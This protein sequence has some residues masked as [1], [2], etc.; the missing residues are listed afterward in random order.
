MQLNSILFPAPK[1]SYSAEQLNG[2]L[3]WVPKLRKTQFPLTR[4]STLQS[5]TRGYFSQPSTSHHVLQDSKKTNIPHVR[6]KKTMPKAGATISESSHNH[7]AN[8]KG[9]MTK[10][11]QI[12]KLTIESCRSEPR[13]YNGAFI[14]PSFTRQSDSVSPEI[15]VLE[16]S[17]IMEEGPIELKKL[18]NQN[19]KLLATNEDE[20]NLDDC[21]NYSEKYSENVSITLD[22]IQVKRADNETFSKNKRFIKKDASQSSKASKSTAH[23][24]ISIS[25]NEITDA[26]PIAHEKKAP[27]KVLQSANFNGMNSPKSKQAVHKK[28]PSS[29]KVITLNQ[30]AKN[31]ISREE[32]K[33]NLEDEMY[34]EYPST[35]K[36]LAS[37]RNLP[38][39]QTRT[40]ANPS[41]CFPLTKSFDFDA[42][43]SV[44]SPKN[45][46]LTASLA[47]PTGMSSPSHVSSPTNRFSSNHATSA[48][49]TETIEYY[50][51]CMVLKS[52][53]PTSKMLIYF[54]GNGEDIYLAYDL[55]SHIR[56]NLSVI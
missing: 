20:V 5:D 23:Q 36:A 6:S 28:K 56:N 44:R 12:D 4:F 18:V 13:I 43:A 45:T 50:I 35:A 29:T 21:D 24:D 47:I 54:H 49:P 10:I 42:F 19:K 52:T 25:Q 26:P 41:I 53:L 17:E 38:K 48:K 22:E 37:P 32:S 14:N 46:H 27:L 8:T 51:P 15:S 11:S 33:L 16:G 55:L 30:T 31:Q 2:E 3:I 7:P 9:R 39:Y 1:C 40:F 34:E